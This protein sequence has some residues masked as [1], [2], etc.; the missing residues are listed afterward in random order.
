MVLE[1]LFK[2]I[3]INDYAKKDLEEIRD[4]F[5]ENAYEIKKEFDKKYDEGIL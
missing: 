4:Y 5:I 3:D 1:D 2:S